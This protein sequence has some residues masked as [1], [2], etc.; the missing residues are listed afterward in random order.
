MRSKISPLPAVVKSDIH[1]LEKTAFHLVLPNQN[2]TY[3]ML[4][5][6]EKCVFQQLQNVSEIYCKIIYSLPGPGI[7]IPP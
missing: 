2:P 7:T 4:P 6:L 5:L 1:V 3:D